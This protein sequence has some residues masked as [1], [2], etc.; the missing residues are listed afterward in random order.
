MD[1]FVLDM[2]NCW[3]WTFSDRIVRLMRLKH[4]IQH[5]LDTSGLTASALARK[6]NLPKT[7]IANWLAGVAPRDLV[8]L[9]KLADCIGVSIDTLTF[10][11]F[12]V[13]MEIQSNQISDL[14]NFFQGDFRIS[15]QRIKK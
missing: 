12:A 7:T 15:I 6:A 10:S 5:Y 11:D 9:K 3:S 14:E 2:E 1:Q 13:P 4:N 8:Q